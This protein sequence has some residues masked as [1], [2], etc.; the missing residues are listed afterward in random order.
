M[1]ITVFVGG[2]N[3]ARAIIGGLLR[4]GRPAS[5]IHVVEPHEAT[6]VALQHD[7]GIAAHAQA[8]AVVEQASLLVWAVKP[9]MLHGAI[10]SLRHRLAPCLHLSIAAGITTDTLAVWLGSERIVRAM[11]NTPAL[12][13][14]G[15]TGLFARAGASAADRDEAQAVAQA[16][17]QSLWVE[18]EAQLD[19]VTAISGSGP[20]YVF[21]FLEAMREAGQQM[22]LSADQAYQLAVAT[23]EGAA[24]LAAD[25]TEPPEVLRQRV[26]SKGGTTYAATTRLDELDVKARFIE[27][28]QACR[29][30]A[31]E[32]ARQFS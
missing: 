4:H 23:F 28:M 25:S 24:A 1:S 29:D 30:R 13:G 15:M 8:D 21:Y 32:M 20:A 31:A 18:Q 6:R 2:G 16:M 10:E 14:K 9:Q 12:V 19:A 26:T 17:G 27:A 11:P 22:G 5:S 7:F 3:M